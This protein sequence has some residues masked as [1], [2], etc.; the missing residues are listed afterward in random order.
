VILLFDTYKSCGCS[1]IYADWEV[2]DMENRVNSEEA[3]ADGDPFEDEELVDRRGTNGR[4]F[5]VRLQFNEA[6]GCS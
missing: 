6:S 1:W 5:Y 2:K 4:S 3:D